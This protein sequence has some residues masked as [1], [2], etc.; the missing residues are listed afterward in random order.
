MCKL[1]MG[2]G[3]KHKT[4]EKTIFKGGLDKMNPQ[5]KTEVHFKVKKN[6][7]MNVSKKL[8]S[9]GIPSKRDWSVD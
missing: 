3:K 5:N 8:K 9:K 7:E 6:Q 1:R 2:S 4:I